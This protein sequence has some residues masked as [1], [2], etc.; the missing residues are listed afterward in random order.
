MNVWG[1]VVIVF[2]FA[3]LIWRPNY[4]VSLLAI[5]GIVALIAFFGYLITGLL[6]GI[7]ILG[8]PKRKQES[9]SLQFKILRQK[10]ERKKMKEEL[11]KGIG[12]FGRAARILRR[13][14]EIEKM[15]S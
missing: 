15:I 10:V 6:F 14:K 7:F 2:L 8:S 4:F 5:V 13:D 9:Q 12:N 1:V 3:L 11:D